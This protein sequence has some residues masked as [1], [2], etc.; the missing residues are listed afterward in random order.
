MA[1]AETQRLLQSLIDMKVQVRRLILNQIIPAPGDE[2][3]KQRATSYLDRLRA[4]QERTMVRL[5]GLAEQADVP[6]I[7]VSTACMSL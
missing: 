2:E 3:G 4:G 5:K 7:K 6:L 1:A